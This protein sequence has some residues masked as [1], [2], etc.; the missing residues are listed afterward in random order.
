MRCLE[1]GTELGL[2]AL[3][4]SFHLKSLTKF[5]M[6]LLS[7]CGCSWIIGTAA[8]FLTS[9]GI[10]AGCQMANLWVSTIVNVGRMAEGGGGGRGEGVKGRGWR[11][12]RSKGG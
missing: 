11:G 1:V 6:F 3:K 4:L 5:S 2:A 12:Q 9:V 8:V 7:G 10:P